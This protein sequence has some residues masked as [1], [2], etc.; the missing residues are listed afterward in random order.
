MVAITKN[1]KDYGL[2]NGMWSGICV[3]AEMKAPENIQQNIIY[4]STR[5]IRSSTNG[6]IRDHMV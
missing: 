2:W 1:V 3:K 6:I 5:N 4:C